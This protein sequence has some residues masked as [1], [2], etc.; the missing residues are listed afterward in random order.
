MVS[1]LHSYCREEESTCDFPSQFATKCLQFCT[2]SRRLLYDTTPRLHDLL[3]RPLNPDIWEIV[4]STSSPSRRRTW[5]VDAAQSAP[6]T[7][8]WSWVD[9][10]SPSIGPGSGRWACSRTIRSCHR[11]RVAHTRRSCAQLSSP[12]RLDTQTRHSPRHRSWTQASL[13]GFRLLLL[14]LLGNSSWNKDYLMSESCLKQIACLRMNET[15]RLACAAARVEHEKRIFWVHHFGSAFRR[16]FV[17]D[18]SIDSWNAINR[19]LLD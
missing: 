11:C 10:L 16:V 7:A 4:A 9:P 8:G 14:I 2:Y 5:W 1:I 15:F 3:V 17:Q 13:F 12:R 18:L 19:F 6:S